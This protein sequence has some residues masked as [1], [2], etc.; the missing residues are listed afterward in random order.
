MKAVVFDSY[1]P[2]SVLKLK[3][4]DT[5]VP[6][7][8]EV[9]I[10]IKATA[11]NTGD[12]RL[13][14]AEPFMVR[15]FFGLLKPK[16]HILGVVISGVVE[17]VTEGVTKYKVGDE[18]FGLTDMLL[19]S[20]AEYVCLPQDAPIA[21]KPQELTHEQAA[22]I[23]FGG[24]AAMDFLRKAGVKAGDKVLI[25]GASGAVGTAAVMLAKYFGAHVTGV[26]SAANIDM[27]KSLGADEVI[28][29][30]SAA[31]KDHQGKYDIIFETVDKVK[32]KVLEP[33]LEKGGTIILGSAMIGGM[34]AAMF[35]KNKVL[36]GM[37]EARAD[38]MA[39]LAELAT[40]GKYQAVIDRTYPLA[41]MSEAHA[42]VE[43]GHKKGNVAIVV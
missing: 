8:G 18:V 30:N 39:L 26:C 3:E 38:D 5:P 9:L 35:S 43:K 4:V 12:V 42:Y 31:W 2:P 23:P 6:A 32:L 19:S 1:G 10:R 21:L 15:L 27:V 20:Y 11:V 33:L 34:L 16:K 17:Q 36:T 37:V 22:V 41:E 28:D 29:R 14:K 25:Y 40:Q 7:K 24:H 13:R